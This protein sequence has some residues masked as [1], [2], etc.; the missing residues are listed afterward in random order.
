MGG[1]AAE[2]VPLRDPRDSVQRSDESP[3]AGVSQLPHLE[4]QAVQVADAR[5]GVRPHLQR[6][7]PSEDFHAPRTP[8]GAWL[9]NYWVLGAG[10]RGG[11]YLLAVGIKRK[12][13]QQSMSA[14]LVQPVF[15][16]RTTESFVTGGGCLWSL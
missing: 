13:S 4:A 2:A 5:G 1:S 15:Q 6:G 14:P 7:R 3:P 12:P 8:S 10:H 11:S 9:V 16:F